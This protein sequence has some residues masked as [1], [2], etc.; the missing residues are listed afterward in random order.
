MRGVR[1]G[2]EEPRQQR[3]LDE[4]NGR[5]FSPGFEEGDRYDIVRVSGG[6]DKPKAVP[7]QAVAVPIEDA[8]EGLAS[9]FQG[10]GPIGSIGRHIPYC[11]DGP[12]WFR[13]VS[14]CRS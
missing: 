9:A 11:P 7:E 5:A 12:D 14:I 10:G 13:L 2:D 4:T 8:T 1:R 3:T 6:G